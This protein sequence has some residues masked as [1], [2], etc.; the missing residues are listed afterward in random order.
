MR[1]NIDIDGVIRNIIPNLIQTYKEQ[2][3]IYSKLKEE[4]IKTHDVT[5]EMP[6]I[7]DV[8]EY[9][10]YNAE[11]IFE[12]SKPY[13]GALEFLDQLKSQRH[14]IQIVTNQIPPTEINTMKWL[15]EYSV[16][17]DS[18]HF[19]RDKTV[20]KGEILFDDKIKNLEACV[21]ETI[22]IVMDRPWNQKFKGLRVK[23]YQDFFEHI[24]YLTH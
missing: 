9:L 22:P 24:Q 10:L 5:V 2:Y 1:L 21:N 17:Y 19:A 18:L 6:L 16:P 4:D 8:K 12:L 14:T 3:D 15:N 13:P 20:V 23:Q 7:K 11:Y